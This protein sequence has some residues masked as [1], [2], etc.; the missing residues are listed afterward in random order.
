MPEDDLIPQYKYRLF[1]LCIWTFETN[2]KILKIEKRDNLQNPQ[3]YR[4][5]DRQTK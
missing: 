3:D 1:L 2:G 4:Q 5:T